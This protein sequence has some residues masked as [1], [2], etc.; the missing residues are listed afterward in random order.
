MRPEP[1]AELLAADDIAGPLE[2]RHQ[3]AERLLL[4]RDAEAALAELA[5]RQIQLEG[6]EPDDARR[7][8]GVIV[9]MLYD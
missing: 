4:K 3:D 1:S 7:A 2:Q 6:A 9:S 5:V 8:R